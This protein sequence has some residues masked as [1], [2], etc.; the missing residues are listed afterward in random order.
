MASRTAADDRG[1]GYGVLMISDSTG[2]AEVLAMEKV[3]HFL[4]PRPVLVH[5]GMYT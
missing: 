4:V 1:G 5:R 3:R 2:A